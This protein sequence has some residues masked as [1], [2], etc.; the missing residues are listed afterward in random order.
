MN[1]AQYLLCAL[2][3]LYFHLAEAD[4]TVTHTFVAASGMALTSPS[5]FDFASSEVETDAMGEDAYQSETEPSA[6]A[7]DSQERS[8]HSLLHG[9]SGA[10]EEQ[11]TSSDGN[12]PTSLL[13]S[14]LVPRTM[15]GELDGTGPVA[16][17]LES[18]L[19]LT[20]TSIATDFTVVL[21]VPT[22]APT[23]SPTNSS[24]T[25]P[26]SVTIKLPSRSDHET[27]PAAQF[28]H[29]D[30]F[31]T[32]P[33]TE[34]S[35]LEDQRNPLT[36]QA[37]PAVA[38]DFP[39][40]VPQPVSTSFPPGF[41]LSVG[42]STVNGSTTSSQG[43]PIG[44]RTEENSNTLDPSYKTTVETESKMA[45]PKEAHEFRITTGKGEPW[46]T[47]QVVC[48]DWNKLA[49][50]SYVILNM[51]ENSE[52][53]VFRSL[54]GL[55]LLKIVA[56]S[57]SR[58]LRTPSNSWLLSL[59]KPSEGDQHLLMMLAS[60]RGT[61]PAKEV[62]AML[63]EVKDDLKEIGIRNITAAT[64]CQERP[65]HPRGDY[66]KLF[67]VLV[68]IGSICA[69]II[70]SGF[71]YICWQRQLPKSTHVSHGEELHF[72]ENGCHDNPTL[73]L[74][75]DSTVEMQEKKPSVNGDALERSGG[76]NALMNKSSKDEGDSFEEDTHL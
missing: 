73:D 7:R 14:S 23:T 3:S 60:D 66:G 15:M 2:G 8:N 43:P 54:K 37:G 31:S 20:P 12:P 24:W 52:C 49:G 40:N 72:V 39:A 63:G 5:Q 58:K 41:T 38:L 64:G 45:D 33:A 55:E 46:K 18:G 11:R 27:D 25:R 67:I 69:V 32:S 48:R 19:S 10:Q 42:P 68:I 50:K 28:D 6:V 16:S 4:D 13:P 76:W 56:E 57:F 35:S 30:P 59:S 65:G 71:V 74:T 26:S 17:T 44:A 22:I 29:V 34:E 51:T 47:M 1:L 21:S 61:I 62:L 9:D 75:I 70:V 53:E 36:T